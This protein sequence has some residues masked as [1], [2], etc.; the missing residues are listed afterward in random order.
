MQ[1]NTNSCNHQTSLVAIKINEDYSY[2]FCWILL[3]IKEMVSMRLDITYGH[4]RTVYVDRLFA[5]IIMLDI[6]DLRI[7]S[8]YKNR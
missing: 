5:P 1:N 7:L 4:I 8:R 3:L 6:Q 2:S